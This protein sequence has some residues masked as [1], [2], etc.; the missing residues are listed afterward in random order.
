MEKEIIKTQNNDTIA[1]NGKKRRLIKKW[2]KDEDSMLLDIV[3]NSSNPNWKQL[4]QKIKGRSSIQCASRYKRIRPEI[5]RG[6]WSK[7]EDQLLLN[8]IQQYGHDWKTISKKICHRNSKQI[9]DRFLNVL[10][11]NAKKDKF[12][13][14]EDRKIF[15]FY[16]IY[17]RKWTQISKH[18]SGRTGDMVKNRFYSILR[19][20]KVSFSGNLL[21]NG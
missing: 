19:Q 9:R 10:D 11:I 2:T 6:S 20:K 16:Q 5:K 1:F 15:E 8:M 14:D 3:K 21:K 13:L 7:E 18:I 12:S 4:S 17:G